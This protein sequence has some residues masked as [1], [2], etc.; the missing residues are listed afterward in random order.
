[1]TALRACLALRGEFAILEE[2]LVRAADHP[3]LFH[4]GRGWNYRFAGF[5]P[6][7]GGFP[8]SRSRPGFV[9]IRTVHDGDKTVVPRDEGSHE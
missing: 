1:M 3:R 8:A 7:V 5:R 6:P 4:G 2:L 9:A